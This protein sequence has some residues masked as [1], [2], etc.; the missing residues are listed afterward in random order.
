VDNRRGNGVAQEIRVILDTM[1]S[2]EAKVTLR[3]V[4]DE[5]EQLARSYEAHGAKPN[6]HTR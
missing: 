1:V 2:P 4:L 5:Y 3:Q 6:G